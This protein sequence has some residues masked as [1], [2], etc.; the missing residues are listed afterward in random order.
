MCKQSSRILSI[1]LVIIMIIN[2]L[3]SHALALDEKQSTYNDATLQDSPSVDGLHVVEELVDRR[4]EYTKEFRLSNGFRVASVYG[5]PVHYEENGEWQEIDN[6]LKLSGTRS[7][8][9]YTNTAG[10]WDVSFPQSLGMDKYISIIKDGHALSFRMDGAVHEN[11][12]EPQL[13]TSEAV[14][15]P[16]VP[17]TPAISE[18]LEIFDEAEKTEPTAAEENKVE[19]ANHSVFTMIAPKETVTEMKITSGTIMMTMTA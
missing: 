13:G 14:K 12:G 8:N 6:T 3:P 19:N 2:M 16:T 18:Q 11:Q 15:T 10:I 7:G 9:S 4:S 1:L 5:Y 17:D